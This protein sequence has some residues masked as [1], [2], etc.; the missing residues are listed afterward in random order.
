MN[1][2][3]LNSTYYSILLVSEDFLLTFETTSGSQQ[4]CCTVLGDTAVLPIGI[5][6]RNFRN[7]VTCPTPL[8]APIMLIS[9][10]VTS[11]NFIT[12]DHM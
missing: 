7:N 12:S 2:Y 11:D 10:S 3:L 9:I 8:P 6:Q 5:D 1:I 4:Y